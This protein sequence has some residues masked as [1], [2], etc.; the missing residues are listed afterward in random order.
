MIWIT[1]HARKLASCWRLSPAP[2]QNYRLVL[3]WDSIE[4]CF[5]LLDS[6]PGNTAA[7]NSD[8]RRP[9]R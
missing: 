5:I 1:H 9:I 8:A 6:M 3:P 4:S 7:P 2:F